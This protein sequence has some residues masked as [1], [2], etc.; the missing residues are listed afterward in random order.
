[1]RLGIREISRRVAG[2]EKTSR[3]TEGVLSF[4]DGSTRA[5]HVRDVLDLTLAAFRREHARLEALPPEPGRYDA[6]LDLLGNAKS[7]ESTEPLV[8]MIFES[9]SNSKQEVKA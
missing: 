1:M 3:A 7:V 9:F 8:R 4:A 2:L 5:I 6:T